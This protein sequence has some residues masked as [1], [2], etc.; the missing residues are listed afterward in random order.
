MRPGR[1]DRKIQYKLSTQAQAEGLFLRFYPES[2][3][4][5]EL[6]RSSNP[7]DEKKPSQDIPTLLHTLAS[8]FGNAI[9]LHEFSTAELQGYLLGCKTSPCQA[10]AGVEAW[11]ASEIAERQEKTRSANEQQKQ[12][13][14]NIYGPSMIPGLGMSMGPMSTMGMYS[15]SQLNGNAVS[16]PSSDPSTAATPGIPATTPEVTPVVGAPVVDTPEPAVEGPATVPVQ[17]PLINGVE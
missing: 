2:V 10:A 4:E 15:T 14:A 12:E 6:A 9:P 8:Q 7:D 3:L 13:N 5:L 16:T 17:K 1:I 11:V